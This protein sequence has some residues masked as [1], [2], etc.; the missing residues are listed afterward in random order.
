MCE[1]VSE[2]CVCVTVVYLFE[3]VCFCVL[4]RTTTTTTPTTITTT[5]PY[6]T[7]LVCV[8]VSVCPSASLPVVLADRVIVSVGV[9][10]LV[11]GITGTHVCE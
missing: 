1:C 9:L 7:A 2:W 8:P 10:V 6:N 3:S 11:M 4:P 5:I